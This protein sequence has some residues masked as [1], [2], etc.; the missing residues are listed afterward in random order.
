MPAMLQSCPCS[1]FFPRSGAQCPPPEVWGP[2]GHSPGGERT[3]PDTAPGA[4]LRPLAGTHL[5]QGR[6]LMRLGASL[7]PDAQAT[8]PGP[9]NGAPDGMRPRVQTQDSPT[10]GARSQVLSLGS[11]TVTILRLQPR[12]S[13]RHSV[14]RAPGWSQP[15]SRQRA[16]PGILSRPRPALQSQAS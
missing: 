14:S 13:T 15:A 2:V 12:L 7:A 9:G 10:G 8:A 5:P 11:L 1:A 16:E 3:E 6:H 4:E